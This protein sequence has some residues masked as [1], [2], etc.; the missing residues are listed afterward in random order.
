MFTTIIALGT[1]ALQLGIIVLIVGI[2]TR[3]SFVALVAK[4]AHILL[5]VIFI[6]G[7]VGSLIYEHIFLYPPCILCWYQRL[8][9]FPIA[10]LAVTGNIKNN[11]VLRKQILM[12]AIYGFAV[13]LFHNYLDIF[14]PAGLDVCGTDG[15]S[16]SARYVYEF[17]YITIPMMS[18]TILLA[19]ILLMIVLKRYPQSSVVERA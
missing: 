16:C 10:F 4:H 14:Q 3:A 13:S 9:I 12:L 1:V 5:A 2:I 15:I 6:G 18:G 8:A 11:I 7:A 19:G 17:G